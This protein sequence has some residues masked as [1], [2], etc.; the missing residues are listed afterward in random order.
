MNPKYQLLH[1]HNY[2]PQFY[3]RWHDHQ[4]QN[5]PRKRKL[6]AARE[7]TIAQHHEHIE[8]IAGVV[9]FVILILALSFL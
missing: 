6:A 4:R 7:A 5:S 1:E 9:L 2:I 8:A 3:L